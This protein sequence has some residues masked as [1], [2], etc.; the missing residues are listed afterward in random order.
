MQ[1]LM[2]LLSD[3]PDF[4]LSLLVIVFILGMAVFFVAFFRKHIRED[5][6][7]QGAAGSVGAGDSAR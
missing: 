2:M 4:W 5:E 1:D 7:R 6:R 3:R